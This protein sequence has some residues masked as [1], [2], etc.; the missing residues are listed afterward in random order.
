M[1]QRSPQSGDFDEDRLEQAIWEDVEGLLPPSE[2]ERLRAYLEAHPGA[3]ARSEEVAALKARLDE[4]PQEDPPAQLR[5]RFREALPAARQPA[6]PRRGWGEVLRGL[7]AP[8]RAWGLAYAAAGILVGVLIHPLLFGGAT[9]D[10]DAVV[11]TA[12]PPAS[13]GRRLDVPGLGGVLTVARDGDR[14][15]VDLRLEDED[16][17]FQVEKTQDEGVFRLRVTIA[18]NVVLEE[19]LVL[20]ELPAKE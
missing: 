15:A 12:R 19:R 9:I 17:G 1:K 4:V 18:G 3:R 13:A 10:P 20:A 5:R 7:L 14:L 8:P 2:Q 6:A 16:A 11:G